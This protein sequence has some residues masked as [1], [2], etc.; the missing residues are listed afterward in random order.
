M[1]LLQDQQQLQLQQIHRDQQ[2]YQFQLQTQQQQLLQQQSLQQQQLLHQHEHLQQ[3]HRDLLAQLRQLQ[4]RQLAVPSAAASPVMQ[5]IGPWELSTPAPLPLPDAV[6]PLSIQDG[7]YAQLH[8]DFERLLPP[9]NL[10][11]PLPAHPEDSASRRFLS[12]QDV[13]ITQLLDAEASFRGDLRGPLVAQGGAAMRHRLLSVEDCTLPEDVQERVLQPLPA[14]AAEALVPVSATAAG[15]SHQQFNVPLQQL[16]QQQFHQQQRQRGGG[17]RPA[18]PPAHRE[19]VRSAPKSPAK[20]EG[21]DE[22][23]APFAIGQGPPRGSGPGVGAVGAEVRSLRLEVDRD[24]A[25]LEWQARALAVEFADSIMLVDAWELER[26]RQEKRRLLRQ[27]ETLRAGIA[28]EE[29]RGGA[30]LARLAA[31]DKELDK[32]PPVESG[33]SAPPPRH[34][35]PMQP[36]SIGTVPDP[37]TV[38]MPKTAADLAAGELPHFRPRQPA[39]GLAVAAPA[40]MPLPLVETP[41]LAVPVTSANVAPAV[42]A[43]AVRRPL[44]AGGSTSVPAVLTANKS[45]VLEGRIKDRISQAQGLMSRFMDEINKIAR[46]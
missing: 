44:T 19:R 18:S 35:K 43:G 4:E 22:D 45:K 42:S 17:S 31:V 29:A 21:D 7:A 28:E 39:T 5:P 14:S 27:A 15:P 12:V 23:P 25:A 33:A 34:Q 20:A 40:P 13:P 32:A 38:Y 24:L 6:E 1:L 9:L 11:L 37:A 36:G 30:V 2:Q 3:Q 46:K 10:Y 8:L 41:A 26:D 16:Q